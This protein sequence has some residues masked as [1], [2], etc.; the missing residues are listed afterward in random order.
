MYA[1][2]TT[3]RSI[4]SC[5]AAAALVPFAHDHGNARYSEQ[6]EVAP[7]RVCAD[8]NNLP[9]SNKRRE[10]F[11][12]HIAELLAHEW[13]RPCSSAGAR[14]CADSFARV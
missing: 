5:L 4:T 8:P 7:L 1:G 9:F 14:R 10:G 3:W 6:G 11:E 12:N 13:E 2:R